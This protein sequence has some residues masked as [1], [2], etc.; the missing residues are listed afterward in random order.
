MVRWAALV[1]LLHTM[2]VLW[3]I[4]ARHAAA[5]DPFATNDTSFYYAS[6][7]AAA[8]GGSLTGFSPAHL[9]G[10]RYGSWMSLGRRGFEAAM[11][12]G[13]GA[14]P[15]VRF[16]RFILVTAWLTPLLLGLAA[17]AAGLSRRAALL[18]AAAGAVACAVA[19]PLSTFLVYGG[20][21][22]PCASAL[23]VLAAALC[24]RPTWP[25]AIAAGLVAGAALWLHEIAVV[26]LL[27]GLFAVAA[28]PGQPGAGRRWATVA[29]ALALTALLVVPGHWHYLG[30][31]G[32]RL[33]MR[34]HFMH[35]G[36]KFMVFDL[37]DDR[38]YARPYDRRIAMHVMLLLATWEAF[39][40]PRGQR[41]LMLAMWAAAMGCFA[42]AWPLGDAPGIRELQPYRYTASAE[43]FLVLPTCFGLRRLVAAVR[44]ANAP[45]R[46]A[47]LA[48]GLAILPALTGTLLDLHERAPWQG[49]TADERAAVE[50]VKGYAA[51]GRIGC[52]TDGLGNLLPS[53]TG[54]E[55]IGGGLSRHSVLVQNWA[56]I[57]SDW[58]FGRPNEE[59]TPAEFV[60][61]CGL[62]NVRALVVSSP[63]LVELV[64]YTPAVLTAQFGDLRIYT[65]E[66]EPAPGIWNG[67]YRGQIDAAAN[68]LTIHG[69]PAG[70]FVLDY[71]FVDGCK[72]PEGVTVSAAEVPPAGAPLLAVDNRSGRETI[73]LHWGGAR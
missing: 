55:V 33:P 58:S 49:L 18:A 5:D 4:P 71:H 64:E 73:E 72:P 8:E 59:L 50:W 24:C 39:A 25:R 70:R 62:L 36:L 37:L 12:W 32:Q 65:L 23:A 69:A 27:A 43:L 1:L 57:S 47:I 13:P 28:Q 31:L 61:A 16:Y 22:F 45:G 3:S 41:S 38:A 56:D 67:C 46:A 52:E 60:A 30:Q 11:L 2:L 35:G 66:P 44:A 40:P 9:A 15:G 68:R 19:D 34:P 51:P 48:L 17:F 29:G 10:Y 20:T 26:P 53:L 42:F 21:A 6:G 54:R 14:T 63:A 7:L